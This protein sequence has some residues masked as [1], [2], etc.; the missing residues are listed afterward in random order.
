[1]KGKRKNIF[2]CDGV[3]YNAII[4]LPDFFEPKPQTIHSCVYNETIG[5]TGASKALTICKLFFQTT[6]HA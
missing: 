5:N 1:M 2:V 3:S 6:L 4:T